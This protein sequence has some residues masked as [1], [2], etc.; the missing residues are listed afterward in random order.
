MAAW[1]A[2]A[3]EALSWKAAVSTVNALHVTA[4]ALQADI[5]KANAADGVGVLPARAGSPDLANFSTTESI[6]EGQPPFA[7][8]YLM[9]P[10]QRPEIWQTTIAM[11]STEVST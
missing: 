3:V 8:N 11:D 5:F 6:L 9:P 2:I 7:V 1:V 10:A 4:A